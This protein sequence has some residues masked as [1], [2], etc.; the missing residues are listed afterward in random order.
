MKSFAHILS[1]SFW[2]LLVSAACSA[3]EGFTS[4][5]GT[6]TDKLTGEP[7]FLANV[8]LF[9]SEKQV[10]GT[11]SDFDGC[12]KFRLE[13]AGIYKMKVSYVGYEVAESLEIEIA[14]EEEK[15]VD[16]VMKGGVELPEVVAI[17]SLGEQ[18]IIACGIERTIYRSR[19]TTEVE[20]ETMIPKFGLYPNPATNQ[21]TL[22]LSAFMQ[23]PLTLRILDSSGRIVLE[24]K[25]V[26]LSKLTIPLDRLSDGVYFASVQLK[27]ELLTE[28]FIVAR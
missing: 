21:I 24:Q 12:Y 4:I 9:D 3:Q 22:D 19:I 25:S 23:E 26:Q 5:R 27:D 11:V 14:E 10:A 28:R 18:R 7:M 20:E 15:A 6:I 17:A 13:E 8:V 2:L 1:I 16:L